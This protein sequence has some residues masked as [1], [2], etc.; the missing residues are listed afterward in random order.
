MRAG[1]KKGK[2]EQTGRTGA[3]EERE[4][5][6]KHQERSNFAGEEDVIRCTA[7]GKDSDKHSQTSAASP[8]IHGIQ[9]RRGS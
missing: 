6:E 4:A 5:A 3:R 8:A 7:V 9:A 1:R 2:K